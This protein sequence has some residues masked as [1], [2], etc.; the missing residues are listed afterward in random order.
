MC[1]PCPRP[2]TPS[3]PESGALAAFRKATAERAAA[4][5]ATAAAPAS[6]DLGR[7]RLAPAT[8]PA[9]RWARSVRYGLA[10]A[11][12]AVTVGG[13][14]VAAGTGVLPLVGP[15]PASSVTAGDGGPPRSLKEPGIRQ[16]PEA[17]PTEPGGG[18]PTPGASPSGDSGST[19]PTPRVPDGRIPVYRPGR[20]GRMGSRRE[21][22]RAG[23]VPLHARRVP[24]DVWLPWT[25]RLQAA[26]FGTA[27]ESNARYKQLIANGTMGLSVAFD[28]PTQ[29]GHDS[30]TRPSR[31]ARSARSASPSTRSTTCACCS[32]GS[33]WTRSPRR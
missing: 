3:F 22:G 14:A 7:V 17:P 32:T 31:T 23:R 20:P 2:P 11:V 30:E 25:M 19:T 28:L 13:V 8:A 29:M 1:P 9:R 15:E 16:D 6:A 4:A 12:A 18:D 21:A 5:A 26:C 10:A 24:L 27:V 33:R